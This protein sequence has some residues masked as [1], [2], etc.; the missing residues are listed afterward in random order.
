[1]FA[2]QFWL[3]VCIGVHGIGGFGVVWCLLL[4][5]CVLGVGCFIWCYL[6]EF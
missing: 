1:M 3:I 2:L 6:V 4:V 5:E